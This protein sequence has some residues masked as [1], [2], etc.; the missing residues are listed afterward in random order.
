MYFCTPTNHLRTVLTDIDKDI[1]FYAHV[2]NKKGHIHLTLEYRQ[3]RLKT[4]KREREAYVKAIEI[5]EKASENN[6]QEKQI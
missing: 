1:H 2:P 3:Q 4:L 5:L 6:E